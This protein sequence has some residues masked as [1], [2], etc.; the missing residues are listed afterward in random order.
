MYYSTLR[1]ITIIE[2]IKLFFFSYNG[3]VAISGLL[4]FAYC[5]LYHS[6]FLTIETTSQFMVSLGIVFD[7]ISLSIIASTVFYFFTVYFPRRHKRKVEEIYIRWWLQQLEAYGRRMIEDIGGDVNYS[8]EEFHN[9]AFNIDLKSQPDEN[10]SLRE[11]AT[12]NTW[13]EYFNNLFKWEATYMEQIIKFG[14]SIPAEIFAE[15]EKYKQFDNLRNAVYNSNQYYGINKQCDTI[16][17]FSHI[18]WKHAHSLMSL[19]E[20][21]VKH[22]YD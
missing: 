15:F 5:I 6:V 4:C 14:D 12:I 3:L 9:K 18:V 21:Y 20:L 8:F 1:K 22:L 2:R 16:G 17:S 10:I 7:A 11:H 19:P 13:F